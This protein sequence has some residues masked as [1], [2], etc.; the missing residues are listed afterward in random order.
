M[1]E[2][3]R[4]PGTSRMLDEPKV[5]GVLGVPRVLGLSGMLVILRVHAV[6]AAPGVY[7]VPGMPRAHR[8]PRK[9]ALT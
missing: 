8:V 1:H 7:G 2:V 6:P 5:H 3:P 9:L 4:V